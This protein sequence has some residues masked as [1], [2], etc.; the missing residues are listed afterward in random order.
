METTTAIFETT[1]QAIHVAYTIMAQGVSQ[2][3]MLRRALIRM[4]EDMDHLTDALEDWLQELRG[5]RSGTVNFE[6]LTSTDVRAQCSMIVHAIK[7]RLPEAE[8]WAVQ[9]RYTVTDV[10]CV[11][12][13]KRYAFS[14]QKIEA[15][16]ALSDWLHGSARFKSVPGAVLDCMLAKLYANHSQT[17]ISFRDLEANFGGAKSTYQRTFTD[18]KASLLP[19]ELMAISR[20]TP[21]FQQQGI[22]R[23]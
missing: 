21:Y 9:A 22:V 14:S 1:N 5:S 15:I 19:L 10:E 17:S 13:T 8:K 4:L 7:A 11:A 16:K 23:N 2:D 12:G 18:I 3:G 20:L 6:G